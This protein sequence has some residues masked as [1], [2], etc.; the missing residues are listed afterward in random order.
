M[1]ERLC[2]CGRGPTVR[3]RRV[4]AA[5]RRETEQARAADP[6]VRE[7]KRAQ[8]RRKYATSRA[9]R[10]RKRVHARSQARPAR[11]NSQPSPAQRKARQRVADALRYGRLTKPTHWQGCGAEVESRRLHAHHDDYERPLDVRWL[12]ATCH[13]LQHR[14][15][16][17]EEA[18]AC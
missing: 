8:A 13:G 15:F 16:D 17:R 18:A 10:E 4:C 6:A 11:R 7:A 5:C 12:C 9:T 1:S 3:H 14:K 2:A